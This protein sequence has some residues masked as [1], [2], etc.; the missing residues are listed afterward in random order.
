MIPLGSAVV[1]AQHN[2]QGLHL[3]EESV[4]EQHANLATFADRLQC[5]G[6]LFA[7]RASCNHSL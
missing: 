2:M 3:Q 5:N 6:V 1:L 4:T 7:C